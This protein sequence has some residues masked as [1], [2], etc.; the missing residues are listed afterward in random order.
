MRRILLAAMMV[1]LLVVF[2]L[3]AISEAGKPLPAPHVRKALPPPH[4]EV[5]MY[6]ALM[7]PA[8]V[9]VRVSPVTEEKPPKQT[10]WVVTTGRNSVLSLPR[11]SPQWSEPTVVGIPRSASPCASGNCP[12]G[13]F[14][15]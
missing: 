12:T 13:F 9:V 2:T 11:S 8:P 3:P 15:R 5:A 14:G 6:M 1:A 7:R 10:A 4:P